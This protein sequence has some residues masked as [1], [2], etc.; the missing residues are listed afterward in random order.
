MKVVYRFTNFSREKK[1]IY[2]G[3]ETSRKNWIRSSL[4]N[5]VQ[6]RQHSDAIGLPP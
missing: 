3:F 1:L 4:F 6:A 5:F 2:R